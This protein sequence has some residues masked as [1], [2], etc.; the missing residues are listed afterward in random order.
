MMKHIALSAAVVSMMASAPVAMAQS[1]G[2]YVGA[3]A[4]ESYYHAGSGDVDHTLGSLGFGGASSTVNKDHGFGFKL[5]GGYQFMPYFA[6]EGG[7]VDLHKLDFNAT[8]TSPTAGTL[9]G[10]SKEKGGNG[11]TLDAVGIYPFGNGFSVF[12][13]LG[14]YAVETELQASGSAGSI[15]QTS[16]RTGLH[17]G[18]GAEY[19]FMRN[20]GARL[21]W[22]RFRHLGDASRT[23]EAANVDLW[24]VGLVY[25]FY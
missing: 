19:D 4:G 6:V 3:G 8:V 24:T 5:Y 9:S 14:G 20:V 21:E 18:V 2:W 25:K 13:R 16:T 17:Y 12:G 7:Y 22:E 10:E 11:W 15:D 1:Q 23:V